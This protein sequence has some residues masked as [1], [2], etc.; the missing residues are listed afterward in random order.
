MKVPS[1]SGALTEFSRISPLSFFAVLFFVRHDWGGYIAI[2]A[3]TMHPN[4][5]PRIAVLCV[6]HMRA[7]AALPLMQLFRSWLESIRYFFGTI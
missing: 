1:S 4:V 5:V 7:F 6:P 3:A 2:T